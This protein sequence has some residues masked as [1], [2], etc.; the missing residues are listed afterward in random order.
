[1]RSKTESA[2]LGIGR[3]FLGGYD[4]RKDREPKGKVYKGVGA[5]EAARAAKRLKALL[6][7]LEAD[8]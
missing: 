7:A 3:R 6:K 2:L 5:R 4:T 1:M 8:K